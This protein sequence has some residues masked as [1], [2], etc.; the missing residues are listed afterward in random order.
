MLSDEE[1]EVQQSSTF[2]RIQQPVSDGVT[3]LNLGSR[4][5]G[6][7]SKLICPVA[8]SANQCFPWGVGEAVSQASLRRL[9]VSLGRHK[10]FQE[11]KWGP[12]EQR[13]GGKELAALGN[14]KQ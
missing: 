2:H 12:C 8:S 5:R 14:Y 1:T 6:P 3:H 11:S 9:E 4:L 10:S 7:R 13:P